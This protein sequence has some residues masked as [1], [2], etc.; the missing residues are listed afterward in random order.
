MA[1][2]APEPTIVLIDEAVDGGLRQEATPTPVLRPL[3]EHDVERPHEHIE[4][5]GSDRAPLTWQ[6]RRGDHLWS[7]AGKHLMIVLD[8][9][10]TR[11]E[12]RNYW[13]EVVDTVQ[14]IIRSGDPNLIYPGNEIPILPMLGAGIT[15]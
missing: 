14:P 12:H 10:A 15:P 1:Q 8:R 11:H 9:P 2:T 4:P 7:I 5:V 3:A 6:V 13:V